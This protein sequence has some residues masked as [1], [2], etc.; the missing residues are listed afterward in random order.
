M[1]CN[2]D[3]SLTDTIYSIKLWLV[4]ILP[5]L[6]AIC[7]DS[8]ILSRFC[9]LNSGNVVYIHLFT[10]VYLRPLLSWYDPDWLNCGMIIQAA[11][12]Y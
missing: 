8:T 4:K 11:T 1:A 3:Y 6:S 2:L 7:G 9:S 10:S 12:I 5:T